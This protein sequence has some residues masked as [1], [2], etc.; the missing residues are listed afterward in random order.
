MLN[1]VGLCQIGVLGDLVVVWEQLGLEAKKSIGGILG[2]SNPS[3]EEYLILRSQ[4]YRMIERGKGRN[5]VKGPGKKNEN[6]RGLESDLK[7][8]QGMV[9][10]EMTGTTEIVRETKIET[11]REIGVVTG[12]GTYT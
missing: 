12:T 6:E 8:D 3:L 11:G 2:E 9:I 7:T 1:V 10:I 4:G 5:P